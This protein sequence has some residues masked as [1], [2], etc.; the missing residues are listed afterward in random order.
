M[1]D[2]LKVVSLF[3]VILHRYINNT[4][5]YGS[6]NNII[7]NKKLSIAAIITAR[8][9]YQYL[10]LLLPRL[11]N[12]EIDVILVDNE[13]TDSSWDLY[14]QYSKVPIIKLETLPYHGFASLTDRLGS[15]QTLYKECT[16]DWIVH[17]DA[18]EV[19]EHFRPGLNLRDAIEEADSNGFNALNFDEFVFIPEPGSD[20]FDRDYYQEMKRYYFHEPRSNRLNRAWKNISG[21][22]NFDS[23]GHLLKG[24]NLMFFPQNHIL[25]HYIVLSQQHAYS[26]YL[27]RTYDKRDL[28]AGWQKNRLNF[29]SENLKLPGID[30]DYNYLT[31][32]EIRDFSKA[33]P[34]KKHFWM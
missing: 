5:A 15:K 14:R 32:N 10:R 31:N 1:E 16:H 12:Q 21:I 19:L 17:H 4:A 24:E 3:T 29:T 2:R 20:Y 25:R 26:K 34:L 30:A 11:A 18:D 28:D 9:E 8:N 6:T 22:S 33:N 13:S 23:G 7:M 27:H